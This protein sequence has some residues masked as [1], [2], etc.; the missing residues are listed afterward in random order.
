MQKNKLLIIAAC[1]SF[2]AA[3]LHIACIFGGPDW[4]RFFGAGENMAQMAANG[5]SYPTIA[6]LVISSVLIVWGLY[7]LSGAGLLFKLPFLKTCLVLITAVYLL[8]G[9]AGLIL[10]FITDHPAI[11]HN[12]IT[13]WMVSSVVCCIYGIFYLL[14]TKRLFR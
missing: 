12:S 4:Y 14:G 10:P 6:T 1:L 3:L 2:F 8:R 9:L 5:D 13:F 11:H 7:G